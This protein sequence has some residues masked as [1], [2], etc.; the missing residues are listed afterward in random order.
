VAEQ[1]RLERERMRREI[2]AQVRAEQA[3]EKGEE[4]PPPPPEPEPKAPVV[5]VPPPLPETKG[6]S[7]RKV[8]VGEVTDVRL[9][10]KAIADGMVDA[11]CVKVSQSA[12][13]RLAESL[14][15]TMEIPG[16]R[17]YTERRTSLHTR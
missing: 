16:V 7:T 4:P 8:W 5:E 17:F 9:L 2:E 11:S 3:A 10:C 12:V 14:G 15:G 1:E 13:N 6:V